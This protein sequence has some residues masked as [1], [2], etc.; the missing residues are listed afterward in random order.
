MIGVA[1]GR[2][3]RDG[4]LLAVLNWLE[5]QYG[6][7]TS[8]SLSRER[9]KSLALSVVSNFQRHSSWRVSSRE[10]IFKCARIWPQSPK[11]ETHS[12]KLWRK[13]RS[14]EKNPNPLVTPKL[15]FLVEGEESLCM[16]PFLAQVM[17]I[18]FCN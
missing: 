3:S 17:S 2:K 9:S 12:P 8:K 15:G 4:I 7:Y 5:R 1:N 10:P 11:L 14:P 18:H 13:T 16:I 6:I